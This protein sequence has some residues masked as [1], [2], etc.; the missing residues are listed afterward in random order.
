M[1]L[2]VRTLCE[3]LLAPLAAV[4]G[5]VFAARF[6]D[7]ST[8]EALLAGVAAALAATA[9]LWASDE[10]AGMAACLLGLTL[11]GAWL[12]DSAP[13][14]AACRV[15]L[16]LERS[17]IDWE[18]PVRW[19][20]W[21]RRPPR[22]LGGADQVVL[23]TESVF[24]VGEVC[25]PVQATV[26]RRPEDPP[27]S[28]EYGERVEWLA[29]PRR[30]RNL[31]NPGAFDRVA[32]MR[33]QGVF[34]AASAKAG[35]PWRRIDGRGGSALLVPLWRMRQ[36]LQRRAGVLAERTGR[37]GSDSAAALRA[38]L[39][40]DRRELSPELRSRFQRSGVYHVLVVSGLHVGL[41]AGGA[42]WLLRL[43]GAPRAWA[44]AAGLAAAAVYAMLLEGAI[45]TSRAAWMLAFYTAGL[46]LFR[47]R[48][49]LNVIAGVAL[50]FL[51][52]EPELL[53]DAGYQLSFLAVGLIAGIA[54]PLLDRTTQPWRMALS[55]PWNTDLDLHLPTEAAERRVRM[56]LWLEPLV[57]LTPL[58]RGTATALWTGGGRFLLAA[59]ALLIVSAVLAIG[60]APPLAW[61]FHQFAGGSVVANLAAMPLTTAIV[62]TGLA[63]LALD[64]AWLFEAA[65][66]AAEG[67][68]QV[69][70][71]TAESLP[72]D[73]QTPPP[74]GWL[75]G[76]AL[77]S[78]AAWAWAL[79]RRRFAW[80]AAAGVLLATGIIVVH[81]FQPRLEPG[82]LELTAIDVGQGDALLLGLP[83]GSAGL[84]D[85]GGLPSYGGEAPSFDIGDA[86]V[87]PYLRSRSIRRLAFVAV[88]HPD[89]DH[90]GGAAAV[91]RNFHVDRLWLG[92]VRHV[93]YEPLVALAEEL[94]V[95]V[96]RL[97]RGER[98]EVG[99]IA[100]EVLWPPATAD[101]RDKNGNSLTLLLRHGEHEMLLTG[102]LE[103]LSEK[104]VAEALA[105]ID[106]EILKVAHH[107]SQT[108]STEALLS[109]FRPELAVLSAGYNNSFG[110]PHR[111]AL[112]RLKASGAR[113]YR[114]DRDGAVTITTDGRRLAVRT[115]RGP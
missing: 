69:A 20:G 63:A 53:A 56:R 108:S 64:S 16:A 91:L 45:P 83:D 107:G 26:A 27:L 97:G 35:S 12:G 2:A 32:W 28:L 44:A 98:R 19:T 101:P 21:V 23:E 92:A 93:E 110:H 4:A 86:V 57:K 55:D 59:A 100:I 43:L 51:L 76:A 54:A 14:P 79:R 5:G 77:L 95:Q 41:L 114:T 6:A 33:R 75:C 88:T 89:V 96:E 112:E 82:A 71:W 109:A 22:D 9:G 102:D 11:S 115:F 42:F 60:L 84:I 104:A 113:V 34:L 50:A 66:L 7:F 99:G 8:P 25:G 94:G 46:V 80:T 78:L 62:P 18:L 13:A 67:L 103:E 74:P 36:G 68:T 37:A 70:S 10:R 39:L 73:R 15:D 48:R 38:M 47:G 72:L 85:A 65:A 105:G 3:P 111:P 90:F 31:G 1:M 40:G 49:P 24:G 17:T 52:M 61:H 58:R 106:G 87:S 29:L 81:P 30:I